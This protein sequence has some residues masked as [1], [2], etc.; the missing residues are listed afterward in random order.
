MNNNYILGREF[1]NE[2]ENVI[3][4]PSIEAERVTTKRIKYLFHFIG[5]QYI[6]N[7]NDCLRIMSNIKRYYEIATRGN[8]KEE[9]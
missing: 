1:F 5:C 7:Q 6:L 8:K 3:P 9:N 4:P 2:A